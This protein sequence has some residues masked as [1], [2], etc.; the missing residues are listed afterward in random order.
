MRRFQK[1]A[2]ANKWAESRMRELGISVPR[3]VAAAGRS[4]V[5]RM[6]RWGNNIK[7][8]QG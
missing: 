4:Y 8:A 5:G 2:Q 3:K 7:R 1:E 6:K